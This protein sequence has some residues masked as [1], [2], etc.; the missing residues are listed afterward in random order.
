MVRQRSF[1]TIALTLALGACSKGT[2]SG[3][4][5]FG[6]GPVGAADDSEDESGDSTGSEEGTDTSVG[7]DD[8][9]GAPKP[10][11]G[12]GPGDGVAGSCCHGNGTPGCEDA[13]IEACVCAQ[14]SFCCENVWDDLCA[15]LVD[16]MG[17][18][19]CGGVDEPGPTTGD[20]DEP[21][22]STG[23]G[24]SGGG[25]DGG[26]GGAMPN[27]GDCC[28]ANGSAGCEDA[29]VESCV[30]ASDAYCC[31]NEWDD[32]CVGGVD[33]LGCGTCIEGDDGPP[34]PGDCCEAKAGPGCSEPAIEACVCAQDP[35][36]CNTAWDALCVGE[37]ESF[38]CG[39]C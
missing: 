29:A 34:G 8:S 25:D 15:A 26:D 1:M 28:E 32:I 33:E 35:Y 4:G 19:A 3:G 23:T 37:V 6:A 14:D 11:T 5:V 2:G 27:G 38:G 18:G 21:S 16:D 22:T 13:T 24:T 31:T 30:C 9:S 7:D 20:A 10:T 36:C 12:G 39:T 17:C